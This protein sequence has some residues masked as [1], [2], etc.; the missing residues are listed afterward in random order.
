MALAGSVVPA[1]RALW[2]SVSSWLTWA[3]G[4]AV[5]LETPLL[6]GVGEVGGRRAECGC[7][8]ARGAP[9][10]VVCRVLGWALLGHLKLVTSSPTPR[11]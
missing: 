4:L 2:V 7:E 11:G 9:V 3:V 6:K 1:R 8:R 5:G 10:R